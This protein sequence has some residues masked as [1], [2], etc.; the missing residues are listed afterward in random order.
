MINM[1]YMDEWEYLIY[2]RMHGYL[3]DEELPKDGQSDTSDEE[4]DPERR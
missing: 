3:K 4:E 2:L 1:A